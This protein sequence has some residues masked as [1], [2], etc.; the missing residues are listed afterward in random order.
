MQEAKNST[1]P[2]PTSSAPSAGQ[3]PSPGRDLEREFM[4]RAKAGDRESYSRLFELCRDRIVRL[5]YTLLHHAPEAEDCAQ[6]AFINAWRALERFETRSSFA[7]W[8]HRIAVN[9]VLAKRRRPQSK[10]WTGSPRFPPFSRSLIAKA[11]SS[12]IPPPTKPRRRT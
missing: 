2:L 12:P 9:V 10:R 3:G 4:E 6:E 1:G 11:W 5:A 8:L 7:T